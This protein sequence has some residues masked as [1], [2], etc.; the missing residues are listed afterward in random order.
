ML[1]VLSSY[2]SLGWLEVKQRTVIIVSWEV[3]GQNTWK[4]REEVSERRETQN[5][6]YKEHF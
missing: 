1:E 6:D 2:W 3:G 5:E 4:A